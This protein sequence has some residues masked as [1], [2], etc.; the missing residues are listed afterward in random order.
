MFPSRV[1][2][3]VTSTKNFYVSH[4]EQEFFEKSHAWNSLVYNNKL[5]FLILNPSFWLVISSA[6]SPLCWHSIPRLTLYI[7]NILPI[8]LHF[9][10]ILAFPSSSGVS[11]FVL[12]LR[13]QVPQLKAQNY[14]LETGATEQRKEVNLSFL[15][16]IIASNELFS[17]LFITLIKAGS[18]SKV[19]ARI[20]Y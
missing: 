6:V 18:V 20:I 16:C 7:T 1:S 14:H 2:L 11:L 4:S 8:Y 10:Y 15:P 9:I 3:I 19:T 17:N 12:F 5:L 13:F